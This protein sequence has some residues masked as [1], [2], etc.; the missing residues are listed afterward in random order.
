MRPPCRPGL[1]LCGLMSERLQGLGCGCHDCAH[2]ALCAAPD[3]KHS[4]PWPGC[5]AAPTVRHTCAL[6]TDLSPAPLRQRLGSCLKPLHNLFTLRSL[7]LPDTDSFLIARLPHWCGRLHSPALNRCCPFSAP[8]YLASSRW[9]LQH[10][11]FTTC[12]AMHMSR[13]GFIHLLHHIPY[14]RTL[15]LY[16][17]GALDRDGGNFVIRHIRCRY[18]SAA[19]RP[20]CCSLL[21]LSLDFYVNDL[22]DCLEFPRIMR[23]ARTTFPRTFSPRHSA[24]HAALR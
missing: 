9:M 20:A 18:A 15:N 2:R 6:S 23:S 17:G 12:F 4:C 3:Q 5:R 14:P 11:P 19:T 10:P 7:L 22:K 13:I 24:L 1:A 8:L 16:Q 21:F